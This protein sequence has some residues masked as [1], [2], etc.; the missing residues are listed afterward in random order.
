MRWAFKGF[1]I[2][3]GGPDAWT[4]IQK[5]INLSLPYI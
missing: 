5:V 1:S 3:T 2:E 4:E